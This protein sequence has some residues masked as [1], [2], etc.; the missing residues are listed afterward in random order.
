[1]PSFFDL[2]F[3]YFLKVF[4]KQKDIICYLK[5]TKKRQSLAIESFIVL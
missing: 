1:M 2:F 3:Y 4:F 5:D